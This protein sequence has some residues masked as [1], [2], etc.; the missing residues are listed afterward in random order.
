LIDLTYEA[1]GSNLFTTNFFWDAFDPRKKNEDGNCQ[2]KMVG[3]KNMKTFDMV[4]H[5]ESYGVINT[6]NYL[7]N[8]LSMFSF[9]NTILQVLFSQKYILP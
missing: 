8:F 2:V 4:N 9:F 6:Y 3:L 1:Q 5:M 7:N